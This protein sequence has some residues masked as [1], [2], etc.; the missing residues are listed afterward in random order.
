MYVENYIPHGNILP[1]ID[2]MISNGG[3]GGTQ[4]AL[5]HGIPLIISGA[6]EDKMEVAARV[7]NSGAGINLRQ[8]SPSVADIK[9]SVQQILQDPTYKQ[10][11]QELQDDYACYDAVTLAVESIEQLIKETSTTGE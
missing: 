2:I 8:Q 11:A 5:A 7:E 1:H 10:K 4:N 6:T 9:N 3:M